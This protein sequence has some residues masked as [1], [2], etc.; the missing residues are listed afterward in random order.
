MEGAWQ[1]TIYIVLIFLCVLLHELGHVFHG[2]VLRGEDADDVTLWPFGGIASI[3]RMPDKPSQELL[4][5]LA[6]PACFS[7]RFSYKPARRSI[8]DTSDPR[9]DQVHMLIL[10]TGV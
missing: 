9:H 7:C 1:G 10:R 5:A 2:P 4:V 6:G 8:E 3:E